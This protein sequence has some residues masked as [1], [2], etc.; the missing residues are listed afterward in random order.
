MQAG[1]TSYFF[2]LHSIWAFEGSVQLNNSCLQFLSRMKI[3]LLFLREPSV[4]SALNDQW[5]FSSGR[6]RAMGSIPAICWSL[7]SFY[8]ISGVSIEQAPFWEAISIESPW[9]K[10]NAEPLWLRQSNLV[11]FTFQILALPLHV[12]KMLSSQISRQSAKLSLSVP[13]KDTIA[14][15]IECNCE[16]QM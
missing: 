11:M 13:E 7:F 6:A 9:K 8:L 5:L 1:N 10:I 4:L 15:N 12:I 2:S 14:A 16:I 3:K